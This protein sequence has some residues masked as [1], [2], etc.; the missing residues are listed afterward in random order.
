MGKKKQM[1]TK[2]EENVGNLSDGSHQSRLN[3][4]CIDFVV[5]R[6]LSFTLCGRDKSMHD[7]ARP[8]PGLGLKRFRNFGRAEFCF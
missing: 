2:T 1:T 8:L 4:S 5:L 6:A 7:V 3:G